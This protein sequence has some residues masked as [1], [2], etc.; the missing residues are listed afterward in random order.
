MWSQKWV[1]V[2]CLLSKILCHDAFQN[3]LW[4]CDRFTNWNK[5][6]CSSFDIYTKHNI[7][8]SFHSCNSVFNKVFTFWG[9]PSDKIWLPP[10]TIEFLFS[11]WFINLAYTVWH[12]SKLA[13]RYY[14]CNVI[15]V[16]PLLTSDLQNSRKIIEPLYSIRFKHTMADHF[17]LHF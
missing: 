12:Q 15:K 2:V 16:W 14:A 8:P 11:M 10:N 3:E 13:F 9:L 5:S 17:S 7:R 6:F 4:L 1:F